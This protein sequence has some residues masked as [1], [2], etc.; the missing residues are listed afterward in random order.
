MDGD[1]QVGRKNNKPKKK[2]QQHRIAAEANRR[3]RVPSTKRSGTPGTL[4]QVA[5]LMGPQLYPAIS[6]HA[7]LTPLDHQQ[8]VEFIAQFDPH[9]ALKTLA[10]IQSR[11][12]VAATTNWSESTVEKELLSAV[13]LP[14][15][16]SLSRKVGSTHRLIPPRSMTQLIRETLEAAADRP[17]AR[18]MS[19]AEVLELILSI[20]T[21]QMIS[22]HPLD[23]VANPDPAELQ[24]QIAEVAAFTPEQSV[25]ANRR[26]VMTELSNLQS[27]APVKLELIFAYTYDVWFTPWPGRVT[28]ERVGES[29]AAAF[30]LANGIDLLDVMVVGQIIT[31]RMLCGEHEFTAEEIVSAGASEAAASFAIRNMSYT[32]EQ[33]SQRLRR[34]RA[35]GPVV[36]QRYIFTER[37]LLRVNDRI[38]ALRYQ[39]VIDRFFGSQLY[40]QTFFSFGKPT[41]KSI[42]EAFS[43]AMNY[44]FERAVGTV[45]N[46]IATHSEKITRV[47]TEAE[48][49]EAWSDRSGE[50]P[51]VCDF[52]IIAGR[53]LF[54]IDA[55]NHHLGANLAQGLASIEEFD[56]DI[57]TA[58]VNHKFRQ[59]VSTAKHVLESPLP[60][61]ADDPRFFPFVVVPDNGL[62]SITTIQFDWRTRATEAF[63]P[64]RGLSL[65]P[66]PLS[67]SELSL[68]EGLAEH[69][70]P[71]RDIV[72][73]IGAWSGQPMPLS[74]RQFV[75]H[76]DCVAPIPER[77]LANQE[78][79]V[80]MITE[81]R[82]ASTSK[83]G[84]EG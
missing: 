76:L 66:I 11:L 42:A 71:S 32:P 23:G 62:S 72:D 12:D 74:L 24:R 69:Y 31:E 2:S 6:E 82:G 25:L 46:Q 36:D 29:P 57:E 8:R 19:V 83:H 75:D 79:L 81:R 20:T 7:G 18:D 59:L 78:A 28:D 40:W 64:L 54:P 22:G 37:P 48:M 35:N 15:A 55:T 10:A 61:V 26:F 9:S 17:E 50:T 63:E 45:L 73:L 60:D 44:A 38:V 49:Q 5:D 27:N 80:R 34:D 30:K 3:A 51:S 56:L 53:A 1:V 52:L 33:F 39:W 41:P 13:Q 16:R 84:D 70:S 14:W 77:M 43:Q 67:I 58:F 65:A 68:L 21:E 4:R 47:A